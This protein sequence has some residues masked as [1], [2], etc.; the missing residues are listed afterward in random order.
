M[1]DLN[2]GFLIANQSIIKS[3]GRE[4]FYLLRT[5]LPAFTP[6]RYGAWEPLN[7][8]F[9]FDNIEEPLQ[10]WNHEYFVWKNKRHACEGIASMENKFIHSSI[11]IIGKSKLVDCNQVV[12]FFL[13]TA[14][15]FKPDFAYIHLFSDEEL[16]TITEGINTTFYDMSM[17]FRTGISTYELQKY[18]PNLCWGT[19]FGSPY[20]KLFT[21]EHILS[22]P[23]S[24]FQQLSE[25]AIYIQL[26]ENLT[27]LKSNYQSVNVSR[28]KVK[29][30]LNNNAFLDFELGIKHQYNTPEFYFV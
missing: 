27:D 23:A 17:P 2:I 8:D 22:S 7:N 19:I 1:Q 13:K 12:S 21:R 4:F 14:E 10:C 25:N 18:I 24:K 16:N 30:H 29:Q 11:D 26:S 5:H 20:I 9:N 6:F 3:K 15:L 28:K